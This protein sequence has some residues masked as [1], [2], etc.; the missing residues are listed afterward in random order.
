MDWNTF[1]E[2]IKG[3]EFWMTFAFICVV[4]IAFRPLKKYLTNWG[5]AR[6]AR[7][8]KTLDD[9]AKLRLEAEDLLARYETHTQNKEAE[10]AEIL[11]N[12]ESEI[13]ALQ[14]ENKVRLT[15]RME[16]KHIEMSGRLKS[17][18][19]NGVKQLKDQMANI[20]VQK[21]N[22]LLNEEKPA[23]TNEMDHALAQIFDSLTENK[24][25]LKRD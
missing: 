4:L 17:I 10:R 7:I 11:K 21:T 9:P 24:N 8:Q 16:R 22:S 20:I 23:Q 3:P 12:A 14:K 19:E 1:L 5:T 15:E 25:L 13:I 18:E 2:E 6:A